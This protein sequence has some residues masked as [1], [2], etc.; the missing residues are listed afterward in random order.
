MKLT[1]ANQGSVI[2]VDFQPAYQ[3][4]QWGYNEAIANAMHYIN[5]KQPQ[6][7]VFFNGD[8]VGIE[9]KPADVYYHFLEHGLDEDL[10][11]NL[12]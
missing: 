10:Q 8:D 5:E 1:E 11:H 3:S 12:S 6:V 9:D 4:D 2:L 7:T